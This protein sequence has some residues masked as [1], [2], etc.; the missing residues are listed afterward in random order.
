MLIV[1]YVLFQQVHQVE[2]VESWQSQGENE[3]KPNQEKRRE[4]KRREEKR[5][6][7]KFFHSAAVTHAHTHSITRRTENT[8]Q[9]QHQ[10]SHRDRQ[11]YHGITRG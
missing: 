4:E 8:T 6:E 11:L 5:K 1:S 3:P 2:R 9:H 10:H 7:V